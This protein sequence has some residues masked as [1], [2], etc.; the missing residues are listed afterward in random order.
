MSKIK[1]TPTLLEGFQNPAEI[2]W[3]KRRKRNIESINC[4]DITINK[5]KVSVIGLMPGVNANYHNE[6]IVRLSPPIY[7]WRTSALP[8]RK[9]QDISNNINKLKQLSDLVHQFRVKV[10][11]I[12]LDDKIIAEVSNDLYDL[13]EEINSSKYMLEYDNDWDEEG[14]I[15]YSKETWIKAIQMII[16]YFEFAKNIGMILKTPKIYHGPNGSID[17]LWQ[18]K[19]TRLL[20]NIPPIQGGQITFYGDDKEGQHFQGIITLNVNGGINPG[21]IACL[22]SIR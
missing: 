10:I 20:V 2:N 13:A 4:D 22:S 3:G 16:Q 11:E 7:S 14:S 19:I 6:A 5:N 12:S 21:L 18:T 8:I 9:G 15:G 17:F 1:N